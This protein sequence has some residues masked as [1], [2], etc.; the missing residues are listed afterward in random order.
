LP[1]N[2]LDRGQRDAGLGG[3][4]R[5]GGDDQI[6]GLQRGDFVERDRVVAENLD[7]LTEL[8][9]VLDEVVGEAVVIVDHQQHAV[10]SLP[11]S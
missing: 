8:A 10:D 4:T 2:S 6:I 3:R 7:L 5:A 9:K 1:E 11:V